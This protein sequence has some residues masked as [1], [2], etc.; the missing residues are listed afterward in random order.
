M[1]EFM[2]SGDAV[3]SFTWAEE[4][5]APTAL[6]EAFCDA[7]DAR[8][9]DLPPLYETIDPDAIDATLDSLAGDSH[10]GSVEFTYAGYRVTLTAD[11][12]GTI[13]ER[14]GAAEA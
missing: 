7:T 12:E 5:S 6:V 14:D 8:P 2:A 11:G 9:T 10:A 1:N 3:A 4:S 13:R